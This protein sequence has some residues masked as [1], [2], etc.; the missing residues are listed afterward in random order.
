MPVSGLT[1]KA[2][3]EM[4]ALQDLRKE[5]RGGRYR[6]YLEKLQGGWLGTARHVGG[7]QG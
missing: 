7:T 2:G 1:A 6:I 3:S 5:E 4:H